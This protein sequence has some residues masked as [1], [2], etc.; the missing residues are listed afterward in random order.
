MFGDERE[1]AKEIS[2]FLMWLQGQSSTVSE[3]TEL[4]THV[5]I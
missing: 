3:T 2:L 5:P 4:E 1:S